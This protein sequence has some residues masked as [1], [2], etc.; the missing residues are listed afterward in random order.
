MLWVGLTLANLYLDLPTLNDILKRLSMPVDVR[1]FSLY[2]LGLEEGRQEGRQEGKEDGEREVVVRLLTTKLG[3]LPTA[4][5][6]RI[7]TV[8]GDA[9]DELAVAVLSI[10]SVAALEEW[11]QSRSS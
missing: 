1:E 10:D 4:T 3:V 8:T 6:H 11:L 7:S 2:Q 5:A 9:L